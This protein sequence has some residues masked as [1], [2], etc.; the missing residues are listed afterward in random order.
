MTVW[1]PGYGPLGP[2]FWRTRSLIPPV[3]PVR[4]PG[5]SQSP[6]LPPHS[7]VQAQAA[8]PPVLRAAAP[9]SPLA[10]LAGTPLGP[11]LA[12]LMARA[13]QIAA[14]LNGT[15]ASGLLPDIPG[16]PKPPAPHPGLFAGPS[17]SLGAPTAPVELPRWFLEQ[18]GWL[19]G[20]PVQ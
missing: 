4:P 1:F 9:G 15:G 2:A 17:G 12:D 6:G 16:M 5:L 8:P 19:T 14:Q 18:Q 11:A 10:A 20:S 7:G 13:P 3:A